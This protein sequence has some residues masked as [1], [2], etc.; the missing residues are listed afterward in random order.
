M[1]FRRGFFRIWVVC[2]VLFI[3]MVSIFSY[4]KVSG[5][6]ERASLDFSQVSILM[7]PV[8]YKEARGKSET[9]YSPPDRPWNTYTARPQC[10]YKLPDFRRLYPEYRDLSD[11]SLSDKLYDRAGIMRNPALPWRAL[12]ITVTI[13][14]GAPLIVLLIGAALAWALSGFQSKPT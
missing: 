13:A 9:D 3:I 12:G 8:D 4:E 14:I 7:V 10:W 1:N 2:S 5:E 6:F 11:D